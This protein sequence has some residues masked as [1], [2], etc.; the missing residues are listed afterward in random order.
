MRGGAGGKRHLD[1][2]EVGRAA[3]LHDG[4]DGDLGKVLLVL[5]QD[6]KRDEGYGCVGAETTLVL[7]T[8]TQ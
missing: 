5:G 2:V 1:L 8:H 4:V 6:L 7:H 3:Q